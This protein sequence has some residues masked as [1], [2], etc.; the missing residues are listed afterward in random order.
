M[1]IQHLFKMEDT[2][3]PGKRQ[4]RIV[5]KQR[6]PHAIITESFSVN[7]YKVSSINAIYTYV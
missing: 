5:I 7:L 2:E 1:Y 3:R 4:E 6:M